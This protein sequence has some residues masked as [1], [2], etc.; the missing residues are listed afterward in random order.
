RM[1]SL[2]DIDSWIWEDHLVWDR[3][4]P[5]KLNDKRRKIRT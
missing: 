2:P 4:I 5:P 3:V 1:N